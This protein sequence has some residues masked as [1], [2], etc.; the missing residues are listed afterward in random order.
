MEDMQHPLPLTVSVGVWS[1][2]M[3][4]TLVSEYKG[5]GQGVLRPGL[6]WFFSFCMNEK[7]RCVKKHEGKDVKQ[8]DFFLCLLCLGQ[9][10]TRHRVREEKDFLILF[11]A[12]SS[13]QCLATL[14]TQR[15]VAKWT[16]MSVVTNP[17]G[18]ELP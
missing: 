17:M 5:Q 18:L 8:T 14:D 6:L 2:G 13:A 11:S 4:H 3:R 10:A 7:R 16:H 1:Q 9:E 15:V 12:V